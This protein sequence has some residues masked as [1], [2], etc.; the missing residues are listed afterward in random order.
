MSSSDLFECRL[1][2]SGPS[3]SDPVLEYFDKDGNNVT[4]LPLHEP[5]EE[6][7]AEVELCL[8]FTLGQ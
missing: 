8:D 7:Q 6:E 4:P 5:D 2:P 3:A 1:T